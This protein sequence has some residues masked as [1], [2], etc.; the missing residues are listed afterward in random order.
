M[1]Q[2]QK[3]KIGQLKNSK[4]VRE[5]KEENKFKILQNPECD[6]TQN[7]TKLKKP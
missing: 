4:I 6:K 3:L 7:V 5:K 2:I 1:T